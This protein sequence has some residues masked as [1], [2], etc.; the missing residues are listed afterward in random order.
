MA[1][2]AAYPAAESSADPFSDVHP[3]LVIAAMPQGC[4]PDLV[5]PATLEDRAASEEFAILL[6]RSLGVLQ[7]ERGRIYVSGEPGAPSR[8]TFRFDGELPYQLPGERLARRLSL[9]LSAAGSGHG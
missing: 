3:A 6:V 9:R 5:I 2:F 8:L 7:L 4:I 1:P